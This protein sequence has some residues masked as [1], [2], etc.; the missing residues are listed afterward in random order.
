MERING[1]FSLPYV[2]AETIAEF[3]RKRNVLIA[4]PITEDLAIRIMLLIKQMEDDDPDAPIWFIIDSAGGEVQAGWTII[5][6]MDLCKCPI[7]TVCFGDA[8]SIAAVIFASG[9]KG[10]RYM[11]K[12]ARLMIHQPWSTLSAWSIKEAELSDLSDD[13]TKTRR[14]IEEKLADVSGRP[15]SYIHELCE[16]D[17]R[18][19]AKE[20]IDKG[21][22]DRVLS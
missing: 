10:R 1:Y 5:D 8:S 22:A 15:V 19:D 9:E 20:A 3:Q 4:E 14:E 17:Y 2:S 21:F 16:R 7:H 6:S 12:H 11:L 18:M 13:L